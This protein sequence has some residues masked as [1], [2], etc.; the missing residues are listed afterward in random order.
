MTPTPEAKL[1]LKN[2]FIEIDK[3]ETFK[4]SAQHYGTESHPVKATKWKPLHERLIHYKSIL[5]ND[6]A[7]K[8]MME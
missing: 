1:A 6:E 8:E 7:I 4:D 5:A 2:L 3:M